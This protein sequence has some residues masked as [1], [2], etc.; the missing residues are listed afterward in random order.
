MH[1]LKDYWKDL[2]SDN[3]DLE[4]LFLTTE[5][6]K[7]RSNFFLHVYTNKFN[8]KVVFIHEN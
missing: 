1:F 5:P 7:N 2:S 3:Q 8:V 6:L 4:I